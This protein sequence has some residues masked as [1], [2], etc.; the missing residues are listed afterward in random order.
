MS[1]L[2]LGLA[3]AGIILSFYFYNQSIKS[4]EPA[5]VIT[6]DVS[7]FSSP[8][9]LTSKYLK[10]V[11]SSDGNELLKNLYVQEIAIWNNGKESIKKENILKPITLNFSNN[12]EIID[13]FISEMKRPDIVKGEIFFNPGENIITTDFSI[14]E[15][16]DGMKIQVVYASLKADIAEVKG[17][18]E[19]V[20]TIKN[21]DNLASDNI[22]S[23]VAKIVMWGVI[24]TVGFV[25]LG[26]INKISE[27]VINKICGRHAQKVNSIVEKTFATIIVIFFVAFILSFFYIKVVEYSKESVVNSVPEMEKR[28]YNKSLKQNK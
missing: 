2:S 26:S 25:L 13:A 11:K 5:Y 14:L 3:L 8:K 10:I 16:N 21:I 18:I 1:A 22:L 4:R 7:L 15:K 19:A 12:I 9:G 27:W 6:K 23:S 17:V 28:T 20:E 24:I